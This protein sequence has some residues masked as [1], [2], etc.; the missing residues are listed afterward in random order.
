[1]IHDPRHSLWIEAS[2]GTGKTKT[3]IDR[4]LVLLLSGVSPPKI[5]CITFTKVA[6]QEMRT[7]LEERLFAWYRDSSLEET[8][9]RE[10]FPTETKNLAQELFQKVLRNPVRFHTLHSFCQS[11]LERFSQAS[12][13]IMEAAE[14]DRFLERTLNTLLK[15]P[16]LSPD[17]PMVFR[18]VSS[19]IERQNLLEAFKDLLHERSFLEKLAQRSFMELKERYATAFGFS[20][21]TLDDDVRLPEDFIAKIAALCPLFA[22]GTKTE[23]QQARLL[24]ENLG[25]PQNLS[26]FAAPFLTKEG[27]IRA[28]L[29]SQVLRKGYPSCGPLLEETAHTIQKYFFQQKHQ[30][31]A[32]IHLAFAHFF[33][34]LFA[35]YRHLKEQ[36]QVLDFD[37]LIFKARQL[38]TEQGGEAV[39]CAL[40]EGIDHILLDEAQDTSREQWE[41]LLALSAE[42]FCHEDATRPARSFC[43][44]GDSKQ[45]IYSF[46][47][48][49]HACFAAVKAYFLA[50]SDKWRCLSLQTSFRSTPVVLTSVDQTFRDSKVT[51]GVCSDEGLCH[52]PH[53]TE[54]PGTFELWSLAETAAPPPYHA[55]TLPEA[56]P[57]IPTE[58]ETLAENIAMIIE[59]MLQECTPVPSCGR[60]AKVEDFLILMQRR[61]T[62][63]T[64]LTQTLRT[65]NI[66][67]AGADRWV[68]QE[69]LLIDDL[70]AAAQFALYPE[71]SLT[72]ATVLKGPFLGWTEEALFTACRDWQAS[73]L[74]SLWAYLRKKDPS[75]EAFLMTWSAEAVTLSPYA[76][77]LFLLHQDP[78]RLY[79]AL[80][81]EDQEVLD[82]FLEVARIFEKEHAP[83]L[84]RFVAE[85]KAHPPTGQ[86][87]LAASAGVRLMTVHG[88]KGLQAPFVILADASTTYEHVPTFAWNEEGLPFWISR[89]DLRR[90]PAEE[91]Y[92]IAQRVQE[93]EAQRLLYVA[94]TRAQDALYVTGFKRQRPVSDKSWYALLQAQLGSFLKEQPGPFG[95][96]GVFPQ[97]SLGPAIVTEIQAPIVGPSVSLPDWF[98]C[99]VLPSPESPSPAAEETKEALRGRILHQLLEELPRSPAALW[100]ERGREILQPYLIEEANTLLEEA[101][102]V[103]TTYSTLF[104]DPAASEL[105]FFIP[106]RGVGRIDRLHVT[107]KALWLIDFKTDRNIPTSPAQIPTAYKEQLRFYATTF[108][109]S[110]LP[111]KTAIL[112]T[113]APLL[114]EIPLSSLFSKEEIVSVYLRAIP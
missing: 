23:Q 104:S 1:M 5:L 25:E 100:V 49:S 61:G 83:S 22:K 10:G 35:A 87:S 68:F 8:L 62:L 24:Q 101:L 45:S 46:Q 44:V 51:P 4:L 37:D 70:L 59:K 78:K 112:W 88:A 66:P 47:G 52:L 93:E 3:L 56:Q 7:R 67:T 9:R 28:H 16:I 82:A 95:A 113:F 79:R 12:L 72:F 108:Q 57:H 20:A 19:S 15:A 106:G 90:G 105:S 39:L 91:L 2:A 73:G 17:W 43:V 41:V 94:M 18:Q 54:I 64:A 103:L 92:H 63:M 34:T 14:Q 31:A 60:P 96:K 98:F 80:Q 86:R 48:A 107:G 99:P 65:H 102:N 114:M 69:S 75:L 84:E 111:V 27:Q 30:Q 6:A 85:F 42:F 13:R 110:T 76:F 33:G 58:E 29:G 81:K 26:L 11:V 74:P 21:K 53:R 89:A 71:D 50:S 36:E 38:V 55:W 97:N 77:F 32:R 109:R 40:D